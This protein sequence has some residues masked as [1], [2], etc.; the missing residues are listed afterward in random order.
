MPHINECKKNNIFYE[1]NEIT[2]S[3]SKPSVTYDELLTNVNSAIEKISNDSTLQN[4][5]DESE[6]DITMMMDDYVAQELNYN[7]NYTLKQ[8]QRIAEYYN[9]SKRKKKKGCLIEEIVLFENDPINCEIVNRRAMLWSYIE[10]IKNDKY[11]S[12][13]LILD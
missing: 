5:S 2:S 1:Y 4:L 11:L 13:F 8:I 3:K 6:N 7:D 10:E 12:K 9:I